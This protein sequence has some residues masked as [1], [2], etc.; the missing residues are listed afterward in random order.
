MEE[1]VGFDF[2][3]NM[4]QFRGGQG[5]QATGAYH[6]KNPGNDDVKKELFTFFRAIDKGIN[7]IISNK[8]APLVIACAHSLFG[9]YKEANT[10][11]TLLENQ[12]AGDSEFKNKTK[13]HQESWKVV[14]PYFKK[15]E[16]AKILQYKE[17]YHTP[18]TSYQVSEIV[19]A[20]INGKIDTLFVLD[21]EDEFGVFDKQTNRLML[22]T[23]NDL[24]S[25]SLSDLSAVNTFM[26]GGKVFLL[27]PEEMPDSGRSMNA[28]FRY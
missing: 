19:P 1:A 26:Q 9:F 13:L 24:N 15:I 22:R 10:Y 6:G 18:K 4:L 2:R 28:L 20:A 11:P 16:E 25:A 23:E 27:T 7:K 5:V 21:G 14:Q 17:L 8:K 12:I 3:Q